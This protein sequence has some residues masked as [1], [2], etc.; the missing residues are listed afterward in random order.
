[1]NQPS[2]VPTAAEHQ[3]A[4]TEVS[5]LLEMLVRTAGVVVGKSTPSLG[6]NAGRH[7]ARKLPVVLDAPTLET[8]LGA[9]TGALRSGFEIA[10]T[11]TPGTAELA[12]ARCVLRDVCR[13]RGLPLD[14]ELCRMF[15]YHLAGMTAQLLGKAVRPGA[16]SAGD[17]C[18]LRLEAQR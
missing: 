3:Q 10:A 8:A 2:Q 6:T 12:F 18:T 1:V 17:T 7:A 5:F 13:E 9:V 4:F 14:G 11:C 15:H 16:V